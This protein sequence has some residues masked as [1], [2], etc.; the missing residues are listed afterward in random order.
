LIDEL[1]AEPIRD[2]LS[3]DALPGD[4]IQNAT[5]LT[6]GYRNA[7]ILIVTTAGGRYVLRRYLHSNTCAAGTC[8]F[9][10]RCGSGLRRGQGNRAIGDDATLAAFV[11]PQPGRQLPAGLSLL[12]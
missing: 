5:A 9:A 2:W 12:H 11:R 7:N 4:E 1:I 10:C 8:E 3:R 6:G